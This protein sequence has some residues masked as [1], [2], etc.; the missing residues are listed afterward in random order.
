MLF[1]LVRDYLFD[2]HT[3][4]DPHTDRIWL[5][6]SFTYE[7]TKTTCKEIERTDERKRRNTSSIQ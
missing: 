3:E 4:D 6:S 5:D 1:Q 2:P 7:A